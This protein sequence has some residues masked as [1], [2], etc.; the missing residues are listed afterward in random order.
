MALPL[1]VDEVVAAELVAALALAQVLVRGAAS[2]LGEIPLIEGLRLR[3]HRH[4]GL[5]RLLL[6]LN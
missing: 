5:E 4:L 3:G 1:N 2:V 6:L